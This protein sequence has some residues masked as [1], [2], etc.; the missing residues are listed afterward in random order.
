[1]VVNGAGAAAELV[2]CKRPSASGLFPPEPAVPW[3]PWPA[4]SWSFSVG[5]F[6]QPQG[7]LYYHNISGLVGS[8]LK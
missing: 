7:D 8:L 2:S 5:L 4:K 3:A 1:M 6:P